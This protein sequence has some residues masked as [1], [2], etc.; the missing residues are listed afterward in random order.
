MSIKV[1]LNDGSLREVEENSSV[2]DLANSISRNLGK[3]AIV[4]EVNNTLV[5][6]SHKL[7]DNDEVNIL[8][9]DNEKAVEVLRHS[10]S[11]IMAQA[12]KRL[13][14]DA[15]LA[16]G[17]SI[18]NGFY[19]DF[20]IENPLTVE[21]LEKI[22]QEMNNI[23][24]ENLKFERMD[25]S[26]EEA[27]K[28]MEERN[29]PYK[30]EL[31][32]DLPEG[33]KIS[34]YKQG[35]YVDLCRGPHIPS[36][37]YVKAFKLTS[38]AGA[39]WRGNEKN[40]MLQRVY[41]VAFKDKTSLETYL[42][43]LEEAKKRDHRKLGKELKLF[44]FAEEGPGFPFFL[45]K[46]VILKNTLI[47]FWRKLH[48]EAGYVE[49]E[50]PIMLNK[51]LWETSGH[52]Y[53][54]KENMYTS[55]ID[56]EEFALKP[57]NCP[58]GMLVYKSEAHSYRDFPMRVGELGRVHRHELSGALH[59]LMRV[60]AF[61]QDDAHIF[62]LP[63]Q[64][65]SE[66]KGVVELIDK[67]YS[68]FGFK[69]HVEL[70][71]RPED[72]M[73][74]DEEWKLA[75]DSLKGAL[76]ELNLDFIVNEGDG[77]FYGPKIDFHLEDSIGRT[78]QCG[79]IQLD[80]QLPQRFEL[81]YV[82]SDG[83]KHRPIVIHRVIFGSIE[84]FI[85]ILIE[86]FAGKFPT[87]LAPVQ[88]KVLPIS[89]KFNDYSEQIKNELEKNGIRVEMDYRNEKIGYKIRES[90]NERVPYIVVVGEKEEN[91]KKISLRSRKNG[92]EGSLELKELIDRINDEVISK[93]L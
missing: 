54:Y 26:R 29:E 7:K 51:K 81:E 3:N 84:R 78:W 70:S 49:V 33:E 67:V 21:D 23:I 38:V 48:Y 41:G 28:L 32:N 44:T 92:D 66:I 85:G 18:E 1:K 73:G 76:E 63:D 8:T 2:L 88:V 31:I 60:R 61:T 89:D 58:G 30:V 39:Y 77:A 69:Y 10:I 36:T 72:S 35:D 91:E 11:H 16:I 12:V 71:T 4:G 45:P 59:G 43:N 62:M 86:H 74:S 56:G 5:D 6:L 46:G 55:M 42:H 40:K 75:E 15:K 25:V 17:P 80:F 79:T 65:K 27:L 83:E 87:W 82:G 37:K 13:Y 50:T 34:L 52:W 68:K 19:Y 57:M 90:R 20:D 53:H 24:N 64:I 47:D 22:E 93:S 9:T 14:K